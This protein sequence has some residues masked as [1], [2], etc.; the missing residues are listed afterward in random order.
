MEKEYINK[1]GE[2]INIDSK[3]RFVKGFKHNKERNEEVALKTKKWHEENKDTEKYKERKNK[4]L[5]G[6][7]GHKVSDEARKIISDKNKGK[8]LSVNTEFKKGL[9]PWNKGKK[10]VMP[11]PWIFGLTKNTSDK[12]KELSLKLSKIKKERIAQGLIKIPKG[13]DNHSWLGGKSFEPYDYKFN[14]EFKNL[15][16]LR[17]N[18]CCMNCGI[19]EQ[20]SILIRGRALSIH[21]IN[22]DKLNTCLMNCVTLCTTCNNKANFNREN[23]ISYFQEILS[24]KYG[25]QYEN[26]KEII[27]G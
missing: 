21:H 23:W 16:R 14:R 5:K 26:C 9:I 1:W 25:Y 11:K 24:R 15:V 13:K 8:H 18:F 19:S 12:V 6:L 2:K 17:D 27:V 22:Y 3:G 20:K 10:G 7:I 4:I